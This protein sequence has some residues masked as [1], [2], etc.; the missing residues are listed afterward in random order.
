MEFFSHAAIIPSLKSNTRENAIEELADLAAEHESIS[1]LQQLKQEILDREYAKGTAMEEAVAVP[2]A[3]TDLI[4][5]PF[6]VIGRSTA[7][8]EW[9]SPD[10]KLSRFIFLILTPQSDNDSQVQI[11]GHIARIMSNKSIQN[12]FNNAPD[13]ATIWKIIHQA[14]EDQVVK[15]RKPKR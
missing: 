6:V 11:L 13:E 5:K 2:H 8:I 10:G 4:K 7:G 12:Q 9:D 3:R 14:L 15:K 1:A